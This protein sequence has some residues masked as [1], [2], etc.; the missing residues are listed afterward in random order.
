[1]LLRRTLS[2]SYEVTL[3]G[4]VA[5]NAVRRLELGNATLASRLCSSSETRALLAD[6]ARRAGQLGLE[7]SAFGSSSAPRVAAA[8]ALAATSSLS[9]R[10]SCCALEARASCEASTSL[11]HCSFQLADACV[12]TAR[13]RARKAPRLISLFGPLSA[14]PSF[15]SMHRIRFSQ[16]PVARTR[17]SARLVQLAASSSWARSTSIWACVL[18]SIAR[19]TRAVE[20]DVQR[21]CAW[22][23]AC[24]ASAQDASSSASARSRHETVRPQRP[25]THSRTRAEC[26]LGRSPPRVRLRIAGSKRCH[27]DKKQAE[28]RERV[29]ATL[30]IIQRPSSR[31]MP[32]PLLGGAGQAPTHNRAPAL[33]RA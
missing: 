31:A 32:P 9:T 30:C 12:P 20:L 5:H 22:D 10:L 27:M 28:R 4:R 1:V 19:F 17:L 25:R 13:C 11:V 6:L 21:S 16:F 7:P 23:T 14:A 2:L 8:L 29:A 15:A 33:A 26:A 24:A 18:A 3:R